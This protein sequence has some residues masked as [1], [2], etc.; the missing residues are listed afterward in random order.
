MIHDVDHTGVPNAQ[1]VKEGAEIAAIY[2]NKSVAEQNSIGMLSPVEEYSSLSSRLFLTNFS[3]YYCR[4]CVG[5]ANG[6]ELRRFEA[7][8]LHY[9]RRKEAIPTGKTSDC[10]YDTDC[11]T[12]A[13]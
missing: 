3:G 5:I 11:A 8:Y 10:N 9:R 4:Y 7:D 6:S 12:A 13:I 1:L 2:K